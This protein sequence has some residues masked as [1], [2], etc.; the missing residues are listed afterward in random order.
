MP[1]PTARLL[2][3]LG[4]TEC[5]SDAELL[6]RFAADRDAGAFELLVWRHASLVFRACRSLLRDFHAAEDAAQ[7]TF[8][9]LARQARSVRGENVAGWLFRVARRIAARAARNQRKRSA[10]STINL[11]A[12]PAPTVSEPDP[13]IQE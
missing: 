5:P 11:D 2:A 10:L 13:L 8:F 6:R 7:A 3:S 4:A 1:P 9:A 12:L